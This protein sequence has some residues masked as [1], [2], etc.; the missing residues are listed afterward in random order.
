MKHLTFFALFTAFVLLDLA[1]AAQKKSKIID[2]G[3]LEVQGELRRPNLFMV[4]SSQ[5]LSATLEKAAARK[6]EMLE[7]SLLAIPHPSELETL[8]REYP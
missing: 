2:L 8:L 5:R 3:D 4:E 1:H 7:S 6:W